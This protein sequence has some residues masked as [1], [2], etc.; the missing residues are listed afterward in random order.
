MDKDILNG[1]LTHREKILGYIRKKMRNPDMAEDLLQESLLKAIK[2]AHTIRD[3]D[4]L[5]HWFYKVLNNAIIDFYRARKNQGECL[6]ISDLEIEDPG[7]LSEDES[8]LCHCIHDLIPTLKPDY[9]MLIDELDL[10]GGDPE[11]LSERLG[12]SLNNLKVRRHRARRALRQRLEETCRVCSVHGCLDCT[13][14]D[15]RH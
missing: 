7:S 1:L 9:A 11:D 6:D 14:A 8:I 4:K 13:C 2:A 3:N 5:I 10:S 12:I 15:R